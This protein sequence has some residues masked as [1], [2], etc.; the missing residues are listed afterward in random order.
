MDCNKLSAWHLQLSQGGLVAKAKLPI[1]SLERRAEFLV[2]FMQNF[3]SKLE[4]NPIAYGIV[5]SEQPKCVFLN[6]GVYS[7]KDFLL[8][9][10]GSTINSKYILY[11]RQF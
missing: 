2:F 7:A 11:L 3:S 5:S 1:R 4:F 6:N 8:I 9:G 10:Y